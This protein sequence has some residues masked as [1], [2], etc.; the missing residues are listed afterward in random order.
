MTSLT[1]RDLIGAIRGLGH[2]TSDFINEANQPPKP[3]A[4]AAKY[5]AGPN[6]GILAHVIR[7]RDQCADNIKVLMNTKPLA[8][9]RSYITDAR[10]DRLAYLRSELNTCHRMLTMFSNEMN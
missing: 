7:Y 1:A 4:S 10:Q 8:N 9:E 6:D 3:P 2:P 5:L